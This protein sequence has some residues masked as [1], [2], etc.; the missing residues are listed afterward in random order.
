MIVLW[1]HHLILAKIFP[2]WEKSKHVW[3]E[4][5]L[6]FVEKLCHTVFPLILPGL[7]WELAFSSHMRNIFMHFQPDKNLT[8]SQVSSFKPDQLAG[9]T[10]NNDQDLSSKFRSCLHIKLISE[11]SKLPTFIITIGLSK[12]LW[13]LGTVFRLTS[14]HWNLCIRVSCMKAKQYSMLFPNF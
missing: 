7:W 8:P 11:A 14:K 10:V 6:K 2:I 9:I 4:G 12:C 13:I 5:M 3:L 1:F